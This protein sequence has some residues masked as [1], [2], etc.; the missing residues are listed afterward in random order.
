MRCAQISCFGVPMPTSRM[1]GLQRLMSSMTRSSWPGADLEVAVVRADDAQ[2]RVRAAQP[3][4]GLAR[5][6]RLA[7]EQVDRRVARLAQRR[8]VPDP[9]GAGHAVRDLGAQRLRR[10]AHAVAVAVDEVGL[11]ERG[12]QRRVLARLV[13]DVRVDVHDAPRRL[14]R[15]D[16]A[17]DPLEQLVGMPELDRQLEDPRLAR[18][19]CR[20][21]SL[22]SGTAR[23]SYPRV[24]LGLRQTK[25]CPR[26]SP[27]RPSSRTA[28]VTPG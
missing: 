23:G 26:A 3:Q 10:E 13:E 4:A 12:A 20:C 18:T 19:G 16:P 15:P 5:D 22:T 14:A 17:D 9:V 7:A 1:S 25:R 8:E 2:L 28:S 21:R 6:A 24:R 11:L 27:S